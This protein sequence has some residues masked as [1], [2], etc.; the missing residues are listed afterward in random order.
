MTFRKYLTWTILVVLAIWGPFDHSQKPWL[1]IRIGYLIIIPLLVWFI[2]GWS[3]HRWQ[4]ND[5]LESLLIRC[6][7]GIIFIALIALAYLEAT[8][9]THFGNTQ[10]F[11]TR[12]GYEYVG[13][14]I[15]LQGPDIGNVFVL[16]ILA[17]L[18]LWFGVLKRARW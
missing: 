11:R 14:D 9:T 2:V 15:L 1:A 16:M 7:S 12:D 17:I 6:L 5:K 8:S 3:W 10:I 13:D 18:I 4:P